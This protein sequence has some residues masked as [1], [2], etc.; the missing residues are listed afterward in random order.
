MQFD[1][2]YLGRVDYAPTYAAM[3]AFTQ[4]RQV[5]NTSISSQIEPSSPSY[6]LI[7]YGFVSIIRFTPRVW[8]ARPSTFLTPLAFPWCKPTGAAR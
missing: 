6:C 8:Q 2:H 1:V 4:A 5:I 7:S 3:Q